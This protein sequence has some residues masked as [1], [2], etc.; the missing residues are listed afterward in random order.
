LLNIGDAFTNV[1]L[2]VLGSDYNYN[3]GKIFQN[4]ISYLA[5]AGG[6]G[7]LKRRLRCCYWLAI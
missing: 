5:T 2:F 4:S 6:G 1:C 3:K 7:R